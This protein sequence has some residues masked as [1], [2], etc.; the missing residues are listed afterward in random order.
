MVKVYYSYSFDKAIGFASSR[1]ANFYVDH[2]STHHFIQEKSSSLLPVNILSS[3]PSKLDRLLLFFIE[4]S[5]TFPSGTSMFRP[6]E[7]MPPMMEVPLEFGTSIDNNFFLP[8][9]NIC[10]QSPG[11]TRVKMRLSWSQEVKMEIL[12]S[13]ISSQ[14][15]ISLCFLSL[16][17]KIST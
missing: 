15:N 17:Q 13:G 8:S 4:I 2:H 10:Q 7:F 1:N 3:S 11:S 12:Y 6:A 16:I 9:S 14:K 5:I